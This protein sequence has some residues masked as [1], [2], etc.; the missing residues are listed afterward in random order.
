MFTTVLSKPVSYQT[1]LKKLQR[2]WQS[3]VQVSI[4]WLVHKWLPGLDQAAFSGALAKELAKVEQGE[5]KLVLMWDLALQAV[6]LC[7]E[8]GASSILPNLEH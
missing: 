4:C 1:Y 2:E 7:P 5:V 6:A 3:E 8:Y